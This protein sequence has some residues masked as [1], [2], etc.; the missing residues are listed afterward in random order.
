M[1]KITNYLK[2]TIQSNKHLFIFIIIIFLL[3]LS[4][5]SL[6]INFIS[7]N[8]KKILVD[9][10]VSYFESVKYLK[11]DVFGYK[12]IIPFLT[13]NFLQ[14][15]IVFILG[16]SVIGVLAVIIIVFFKGFTLGATIGTIILKYQL[17]GVVGTILYVF[18]I[19]IIIITIYLLLSFYATYTSLKFIK[20]FF[21]KS[22]IDFKGFVGKYLL[23]F[24]VCILLIILC[25]I[26]NSYISPLILKLFTFLI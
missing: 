12:A 25:S 4:S 14:L 19:E 15:V 9:Q 13:N 21:T 23:C 7:K 6:F 18:P 26:L 17:K 1:K 2:S 24:F 3:G 10:V 11:P 16:L 8:D 20:A 22:K 5:G